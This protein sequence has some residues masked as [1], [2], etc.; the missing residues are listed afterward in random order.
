MVLV[1]FSPFSNRRRIPAMPRRPR[2]APSE[3]EIAQI[4]WRLGE[5]G[6][7]EVADALPPERQ[8]DFWTVQTYMRRLKSK[9]YLRTRREGRSNIYSAAVRP[10][11]VVRDLVSDFVDRTFGGHALLLVQQL[12]DDRNLSESEIDQLQGMLDRLK[13]GEKP[14]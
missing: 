7:R 11:N 3:L 14:S 2:L 12:I 13:H 6:V 4:V 10:A 8:L 5:A 1:V 9:G